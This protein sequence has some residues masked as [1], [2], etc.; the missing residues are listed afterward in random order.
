MSQTGFKEGDE[1]ADGTH[2]YRVLSVTRL[3]NPDLG[4]DLDMG[5]YTLLRDDGAMFSNMPGYLLRPCE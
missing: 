2:N 3:H 1:V 5:R 4:S